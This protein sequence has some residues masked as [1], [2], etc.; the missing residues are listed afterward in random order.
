LGGLGKKGAVACG[1]LLFLSLSSCSESASE[2]RIRELEARIERQE[3]ANE[4]LRRRLSGMLDGLALRMDRV[5]DAL[6]DG[7]QKTMSPM[8]DV[9]PIPAA[10]PAEKNSLERVVASPANPADALARDRRTGAWIAALCAV[11]AAAFLAWRWRSQ[12]ASGWSRGA[13]LETSA[14]SAAWDEAHV[15]SDA[16]PQKERIACAPSNR[17]DQGIA[18]QD[19]IILDPMDADEP[20][21]FGAEPP[22]ASAAKNPT[23]SPSADSKAEAMDLP[24]SDPSAPARTAFHVDAKEPA[25]ARAS[26]ES[27]LR[28]DPRV[29][30]K[31]A[32]AVRS[33][34]GGLSVE[35]ALLP[36]LA[37]GEREHLRAV[38]QRLASTR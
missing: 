33:H 6:A 27:Y 37:A 12:R 10:A 24:P 20:A 35:C 34:Q 15:L 28:H 5:V 1:A 3:I 36:G 23:A 38:L 4:Q 25:V 7:S 11:V 9:T 13:D 19:V 32:P 18:D 31:P 21:A 8:A 26:I 17:S 22:G 14:D 16:V 29:L 30:Q 2:A